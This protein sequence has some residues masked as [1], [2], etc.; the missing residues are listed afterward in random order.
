MCAGTGVGGTR[1]PPLHVHCTCPPH[2]A[3]G[4]STALQMGK[5]PRSKK[6]AS[7]LRNVPSKSEVF[8]AKIASAMDENTESDS[9]EAFV[10]ETKAGEL[11]RT[12]SVSSIVSSMR[13]EGKGGFSGRQSMKFTNHSWS[14]DQDHKESMRMLW[15]GRE[16]PQVSQM[17]PQVPAVPSVPSVPPVPP[18]SRS[19]YRIGSRTTS[20]PSSPHYNKCQRLKYYNTSYRRHLMDKNS[21][22]FYIN[23]EEFCSHERIPLLYKDIGC[24]SNDRYHECRSHNKRKKYLCFTRFRWFFV[25]FFIFLA[26][27]IILMTI[28][29]PLQEPRIANV[30][31]IMVSPQVIIMDLEMVAF[32][33]NFW[34]ISIQKADIGIFSS[35]PWSD[36]NPVNGV[37]SDSKKVFKRMSLKQKEGGK[38]ANRTGVLGSN[39]LNNIT[40][41]QKDKLILLGHV[42][43]LDVPFV[44]RSSFLS[45]SI[46]RSIAQFRLENSD[47][48]ALEDKSDYMTVD[49]ES[50]LAMKGFLTYFPSVFSRKQQL[51]QIDHLIDLYP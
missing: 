20:C 13:A 46:S 35:K 45:K 32:N 40:I 41:H 51:I 5:A 47:Q 26:C 36:L 24:F 4:P 44:F 19:P 25:F 43:Q 28:A 10:Y 1:V 23:H 50:Q 33:P 12:S 7:R 17:S 18:V 42:F 37:H 9:E 29:Q 22:Q 14:S 6:R 11:S 31:N 30:T 2:I 27:I 3:S 34:Q 48:P 39:L 49:S 16:V 38:Y 21:G 8:A 15:M